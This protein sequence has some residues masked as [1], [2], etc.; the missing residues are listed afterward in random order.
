MANATTVADHLR[1]AD[2]FAQKE[3]AKYKDE[4]EAK[5]HEK[6]PDAYFGHPK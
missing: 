2:Y 3:A 5:V 4:S 1:I 6:M